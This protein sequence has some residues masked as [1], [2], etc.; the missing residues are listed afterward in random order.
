ML[1][2][3]RQTVILSYIGRPY[4]QR[5]SGNVGN[6]SSAVTPS[7][8]YGVPRYGYNRYKSSQDRTRPPSR[9]CSSD[10]QR[11]R[12]HL[13]N[14]IEACN[15]HDKAFSDSSH[16]CVSEGRSQGSTI[17]Q[18][19]DSFA[20]AVE[21]ARKLFFIILWQRA[22]PPPSISRRYIFYQNSNNTG[23]ESS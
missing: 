12:E 7:E 18:W 21:A 13:S 1:G 23:H 15:H 10:V 16:Y 9:F 11:N 20:V 19:K 8:K 22:L 5:Y 3:F 6:I 14:D 4:L 17:E 2:F